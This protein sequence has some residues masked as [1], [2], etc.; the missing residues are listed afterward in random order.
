VLAG[1]LRLLGPACE[2]SLLEDRRD[3]GIGHEVLVAL[4]VPVE[5]YPDPVVVIGIAKD[6]RTLGPMLLALLSAL[7]RE[8]VPERSKFSTFT[9]DRIIAFL[10]RWKSSTRLVRP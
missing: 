2:P 5:D 7:G 4:L 3:L 6:V 1:E 9:V 10:L 8:R